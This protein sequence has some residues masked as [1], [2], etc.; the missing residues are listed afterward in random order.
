MLHAIALTI[1]A[2]VSSARAQDV[3]RSRDSSPS[4]GSPARDAGDILNLDIEQLAKTP[5]IVP[6]MDVPVTSVTK[7]KSTVGRSAAAV[8]VITNE[9]IRRSGATCIPEAL[10]MA[11][12]LEVAHIDSNK[13]AISCR[14]FNGRFANKL[15]V[16][17]DGR[18][19]YEPVASGVLWDQQ[20]YI[21]EDIERIEVIRGPGGTL[22][23][24]NA[25]NGV[26][27]IITKKA[28]DTQGAYVMAGGGTHEQFTESTRYGGKLG[29][30]AFYRVYAKSFDRGPGVGTPDLPAEDSWRQGRCGFRTDWNLT[31]DKSDVL[32]FQGD[33]FGGDS[34]TRD[35]VAIPESP[36]GKYQVGYIRNSGENI[37]ARWR[38]VRDED[39]DW[40][41]QA[42]YDKSTFN[43]PIP[44][45]LLLDTVRTFDV[46]YQYR[47]P[48]GDRQHI[49]CGASFRNTEMWD[50]GSNYFAL[51]FTP[52]VQTI[53]TTTEF[54]Q[55]EIVLSEDLWTL[56]TG[57]KL[58]QNPYTGLEYQPTIRLLWT[59]D[60][61]HSGWCAV[62]RAVRTPAR[63]EEDVSTT[64]P[65]DVGGGLI[66]RVLGSHAMTSEALIAYEVGY[67]TQA[68]EQ[69]SWDLA[70][71]YNVYDHFR[72]DSFGEP[73]EETVPSPPHMILPM[74]FD[75][76]GSATS[77]G[78][79]LAC[80]WA[81][82]D[83]WRL[84]GQYT[85]L[86]VSIDNVDYTFGDPHNQIYLRSSWNLRKDL[87]FDL[88]TKW[89]DR[90]SDF[91]FPGYVSLDMRLAWRPRK[92]LE[93]AV[94]G[95]NL[96]Q[97]EHFEFG[98]ISDIFNTV[99]TEVPRGVY[100]TV[101]WRY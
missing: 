59:P 56:T 80:E 55:D 7:E 13:W 64:L 45:P 99:P 42:Y 73:F 20:D 17:I 2:M 40:T 60:R 10:R 32:T 70:T 78:V 66:P 51:H 88:M 23:G 26:I 46:D 11:P 9:M 54:I 65:R 4:K 48:M 21:L 27:N 18:S 76:A 28:S 8:F 24:S 97:A 19:V 90:L 39:S 47:F 41:L 30:D 12:G 98:R 62:S 74:T 79:E 81:V 43:E 36:Y 49:T 61:R 31:R 82:S 3:E 25:V 38:H 94:V 72:S 86:E 91:R 58:E 16:L 67:R 69:F 63:A 50:F 96:L 87:D 15:L 44:N 75:N 34:G 5:V 77:Y 85:Y 33:H 29:E 1:L 84:S 71:F 52:T 57:C 6:S 37:L 89:V 22:W 93:L 35:T 53:N 14:G 95:Q 100:G 92:H 101:A 68:T 83:R